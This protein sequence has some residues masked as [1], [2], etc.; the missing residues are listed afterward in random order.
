MRTAISVALF[1]WLPPAAAQ[2]A[3][4]HVEIRVARTGE[5]SI[6]EFSRLVTQGVEEL[7][8]VEQVAVVPGRIPIEH[9]PPERHNRL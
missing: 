7:G 1:F 4:L 2:V 9:R 8:V 6:T 5:L 3:D